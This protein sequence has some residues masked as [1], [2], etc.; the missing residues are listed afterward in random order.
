MVEKKGTNKK[1]EKQMENAR[2]IQ[3]QMLKLKI[4]MFQKQ[5]SNELWLAEGD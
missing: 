1:K 2:L 4:E 5:I 3:Q